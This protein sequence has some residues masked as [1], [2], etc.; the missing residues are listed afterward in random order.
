VVLA[1]DHGVWY[2]DFYERVRA[3]RLE[4]KMPALFLLPPAGMARRRPD[5]AARLRGAEPALT[6]PR[7]VHATLVAWLAEHRPVRGEGGVGGSLSAWSVPLTEAVLV[8]AVAA[9]AGS[10][11]HVWMEP[12]RGVFSTVSERAACP[13]RT[14][15]GCLGILRSNRGLRQ[16][17]TWT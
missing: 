2:G 12:G 17:G 9:A 5:A 4:A 3:G 8:A 16:R 7:D 10:A 15:P 6:T 1:G 11:A 13:A 14:L